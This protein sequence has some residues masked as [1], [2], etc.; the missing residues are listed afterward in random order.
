MGNPRLKRGDNPH[1]FKKGYDER[2]NLDGAPPKPTRLQVLEAIVGGKIEPEFEK[3]TTIKTLRWL[4]EQTP[5]EL[6]VIVKRTDLSAFV[7]LHAKCIL[8]AITDK[9]TKVMREIYDRAYGK[10][11][12]R[13]QFTDGQGNDADGGVII[14]LPDNGRGDAYHSEENSVQGDMNNQEPT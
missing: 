4:C 13:L 8:Q 14:Y 2:R 11:T 1:G 9:N 5:A 10:P 6:R 7:I 3:Q 12:S